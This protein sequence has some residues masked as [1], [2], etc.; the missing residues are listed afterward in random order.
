MAQL[1]DRYE[2]REWEEI[3]GNCDT[4]LFWG[5][6]DQITA[7]YFSSKCGF[8]SIRKTNSMM[9]LQPLFSPIYNSARPYSLSRS[10]TRRELM[11]PDEL[12][13]LDNAREIAIFRGHKPLLLYKITP[14]ELPEF[15]HLRYTR[16]T[17]YIPDWCKERPPASPHAETKGTS[18]GAEPSFPESPKQAK[19][20]SEIWR[21][22]AMLRTQ[23]PAGERP[24]TSKSSAEEREQA[25]PPA[26]AGYLKMDTSDILR[27]AEEISAKGNRLGR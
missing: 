9:P 24:A 1:S 20:P 23:P 10:N 22:T 15:D 4:Q 25:R 19:V 11:L 26:T 2:H 6:N 21:N 5:C 13:R 18:E 16:I 27:T 14:E 17:D 7:D 8:I 3:I 12:L